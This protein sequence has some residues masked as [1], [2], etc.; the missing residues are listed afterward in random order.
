MK[1]M[2]QKFTGKLPLVFWGNKNIR[3]WAGLLSAAGVIIIA[4]GMLQGFAVKLAGHNSGMNCFQCHNEYALAGTVF[5]DSNAMDVVAGTEINLIAPDGTV[6]PAGQTNP[7]G[8]IAVDSMAPGRYLM[9]VGNSTS[10]TW[11]SIPGQGSCNTCHMGGGNA[12]AQRTLKFSDWHTRV[13]DDNNCSHCHYYPQTMQ[14][15]KLIC[16]R[17]INTAA[18]VPPVPQ[19]Y[20]VIQNQNY[21]FDPSQCSITSVRPDIFA[22]GY[23]SAF[24]V[25]LAVCQQQSIPVEYY[26]DSTRKTHF[27]TKINNATNDFWYHWSYDIFTGTNSELNYKRANRWDELLW[28]PGMWIKIVVGENLTAIKAEYLDEI[29]RENALGHVI[30]DVK[31]QLNPSNYNGSPPGSGRITVTRQ[32]SNIRITPHNKRSTGYPGPYPK[33]F[34]P[35]VVTSMDILYSLM[36]SLLLDSVNAAFYT[37]FNRNYIGSFYVVAMGFPGVGLAH[38]SGRQGFVYITENGSFTALPNGADSKMHVTSDIHVIH[39]PD[40][41]YWRW[42]ELGNPYYEDNPAGLNQSIT[43]DMERYSEGFNLYGPV[44]NPSVGEVEVAYNIFC[45]GHHATIAVYN[46]RGKKT[47]VLYDEVAPNLGVQRIKWNAGNLAAGVYFIRMD[48]MGGTLTKK[49]VLTGQ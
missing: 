16:Q 47:A 22:P 28:R 39:A 12:S 42:I 33:P 31:I 20:V 27:I 4:I 29:N 48:Y 26:W 30:P 7:D 25:I 14:Y 35:G 38:S 6:I 23:F 10:R 17:V 13:P 9:N 49:L 5:T 32:F 18:F 41:T 21:L 46:Q 36:D 1:V 45:P 3:R 34:Q 11:H 15:N 2:H 37:H 43:E 44:P 24:D 40:F 8:N 19:S